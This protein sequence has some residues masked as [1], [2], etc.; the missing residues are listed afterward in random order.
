MGQV[1]QTEVST[2]KIHPKRVG[3]DLAEALKTM[4]QDYGA[5]AGSILRPS[6]PIP[7]KSR[8]V[9]MARLSPV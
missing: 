9:A 8:S 4:R 3:V 2:S 5:E 1:F 7:S 6:F